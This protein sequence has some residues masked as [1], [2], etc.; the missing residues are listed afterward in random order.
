MTA[1][2]QEIETLKLENVALKMRISNLESA[3]SV[4]SKRIL[5]AID[6]ITKGNSNHQNLVTA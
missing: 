5:A 3:N 2:E 6:V 4:L 1:I